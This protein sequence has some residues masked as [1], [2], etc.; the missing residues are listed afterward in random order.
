MTEASTTGFP[1]MEQ[2]SVKGVRRYLQHKKAILLPIGI[3]EQHGY[4]LPLST[5]SLIATQLA[6]RA[7]RQ[8]QV[9]VA[10]TLTHCFSGG[11]LPGTINIS[12]SVMS[13]V[14]GDMLI[15]LVS[16]GFGNF[17]LFICHGGSE[18]LR[19]M[20]DAL[21]LLLRSNPAFERIMIALLPVWKLSSPGMGWNQAMVER[22]WH[23]GWL[24]TSMVM[25][26]APSLVHMEELELDSPALLGSMRQHPD[27]YQQAEKIV[28][29]PL[30]V[31]RISQRPDVQVGVMGDP[32][33]ASAELGRKINDDIVR[34]L[35]DRIIALE[36][37]A[38]GLYKPVAFVPEPLV[39]K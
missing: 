17:Y 25:D 10:P 39:L 15:S 33:R 24:E 13:L 30:V 36:A 4:H 28:D 1:M 29:D 18:N 9:L 23:A 2:M 27:N 5:D 20:N 37:Q 21:K 16:Q 35:A 8:A 22:D 7:G 38:D 14:L 6:H 26:L 34:N 31:P 19:A 32:S 12:P 11:S 3:T